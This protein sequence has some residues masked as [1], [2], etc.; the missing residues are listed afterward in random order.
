MFKKI[1]ILPAAFLAF[2]CSK[3]DNK[4]TAAD[5]ALNSDL[6]TAAASRPYTPLDSITAAERAGAVAAPATA[7]RS[8]ASAPRTTVRRTS[9]ARRS[10]SS[11]SSGGTYSSAPVYSAP[12]PQPT[13]V[14][15]TKRD[16]AIGAGA[17][18]VIGAVTSRNKVKGAI[19]GGAAG[20]ILGGVIGNNVDKSTKP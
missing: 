14:K 17:G 6:S 12:A 15:H 11:R 7:L 3:G 10:T 4:M 2:A 16:A 9:T 13:V 20:A 18:A 8:T 19:I 5:S 1:L